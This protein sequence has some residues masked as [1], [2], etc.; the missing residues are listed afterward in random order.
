MI[1]QD[2]S[3]AICNTVH[4]AFSTDRE[5]VGLNS[6]LRWPIAIAGTIRVVTLFEMRQGFLLAGV[7]MGCP[8]PPRVWNAVEVQR[9]TQVVATCD[10]S[11]ADPLSTAPI[12]SSKRWRLPLK[13]TSE[14]HLEA[15][16][17]GHY[18][19]QHVT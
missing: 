2:A 17:I 7:V 11:D 19:V 6:K 16:Q 10:I 13:N 3:R 12:L 4:V 5:S 8:V 9:V 18:T 1:T 14:E 15:A